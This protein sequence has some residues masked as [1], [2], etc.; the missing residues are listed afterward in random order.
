MEGQEAL[1]QSPLTE[2]EVTLAYL[3][4]QRE[5]WLSL[6]ARVGRTAGRDALLLSE[7]NACSNRLDTL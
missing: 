7:Y 6:R 4:R 1:D 3:E 2:R 5:Q